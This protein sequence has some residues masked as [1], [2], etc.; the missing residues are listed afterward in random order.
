MIEIVPISDDDGYAVCLG[1][2]RVDVYPANEI[3]KVPFVSITEPR[4]P[5]GDV[6]KYAMLLL[7]ALEFAEIE[8]AQQ[9]VE[10]TG[11]NARQKQ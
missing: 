8:A 3:D 1:D 4:M 10:R 11:G 9:S 6:R 5:V 7:A 2:L